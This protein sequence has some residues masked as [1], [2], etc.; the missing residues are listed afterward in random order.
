MQLAWYA[1]ILIG[2]IV[3]AAGGFGSSIYKDRAAT[4]DKAALQTRFDAVQSQLTKFEALQ[5]KNTQTIIDAFAAKPNDQWQSVELTNIPGQV[6]DFALMLFRADR[7]RISGKVRIRGSNKETFFSTSSNDRL[8]LAIPNAWDPATSSYR[9]PT[10]LEYAVAETTEPSA[11][12]SILTA[13]WIDFRRELSDT[14]VAN[15]S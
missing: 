15:R 10:F 6:A 9:S 11:H 4:R 3:A 14:T 2:A 1:A 8:P 12:L 7:G 5:N 13:G